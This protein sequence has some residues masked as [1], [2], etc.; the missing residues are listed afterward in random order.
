MGDKSAASNGCRSELAR[1][2][3]T[4]ARQKMRMKR[5]EEKKTDIK[6]RKDRYQKTRKLENQEK[7][8]MNWI[9]TD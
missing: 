7:Q 6:S 9:E 3:R 2:K 4:N 1:C 5:R 8:G